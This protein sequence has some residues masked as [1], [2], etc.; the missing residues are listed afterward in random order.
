MC[1]LACSSQLTISPSDLVVIRGGDL[2][3]LDGVVVPWARYL[4]WSNPPETAM[5]GVLRL[6]AMPLMS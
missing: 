4:S 3:V 1:P 2:G 6:W 5:M